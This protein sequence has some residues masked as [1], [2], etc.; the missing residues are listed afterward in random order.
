M[1]G[2]LG[3]KELEKWVTCVG[4][5]KEATLAI[6]RT[7]SC[8]LSKAE[9]IAGCRYTNSLPR[10]EEVALAKLI[11]KPRETLFPSGRHQAS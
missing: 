2:P 8:S 4:G 7:L 6:E 5:V 9:K 1:F 3:L 11:G 10:L